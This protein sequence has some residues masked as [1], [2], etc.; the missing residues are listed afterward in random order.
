MKREDLN[1]VLQHSDIE[2][3]QSLYKKID[4]RLGITI[5]N[6][7]TSQTLLVPVKDPISGGEF[8]SGE[9]LVTSSIVSVNNNQ[10][11]SMVQDDNKYLSLYIAAI[12]AVFDLQEFDSDIK[13][14]YNESLERIE[15]Q[16]KIL[17]QKVNSTRVSFDLM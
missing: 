2:K 4:K 5:V 3:L 6:Q 15:K 11:W 12:D 10:G 9:V 17:N 8:Y 14:L 16:N 13:T 1:Y 7:P